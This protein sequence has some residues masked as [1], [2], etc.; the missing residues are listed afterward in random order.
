MVPM[1]DKEIREFFMISPKGEKA[2]LELRN[3]LGDKADAN[4]ELLIMEIL[5]QTYGFPA[6]FMDEG[7]E[8]LVTIPEKKC[9]ELYE[10]YAFEIINGEYED[11]Y[12]FTQEISAEFGNCEQ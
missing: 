12:D 5:K 2:Y 11:L 10:K 9:L 3:S 8:E 7:K 1:T 6:C 4:P